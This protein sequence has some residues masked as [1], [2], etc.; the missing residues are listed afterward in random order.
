MQINPGQLL[1]KLVAIYNQTGRSRRVDASGPVR[2]GKAD[3]VELSRAAQEILQL[4]EQ[5][6][7]LPAL[8]A[9]RVQALRAAVQQGTYQPDSRA[10]AEKLE[11]ARVLDE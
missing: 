3:G 2:P 9:E 7:Q 6:G 11:Q 5:L 1:S 4:R 10:V 8:R